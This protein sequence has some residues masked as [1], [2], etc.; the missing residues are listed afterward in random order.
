MTGTSRSIGQGKV[1]GLPTTVTG[2]ARFVADIQTV[3]AMMSADMSTTILLVEDASATA[4]SPIIGD[5]RAVV[6]TSGGPTSH[7]ALVSKEFGV[8]CVVGAV[9]VEDAASLDGTTI[10]IGADG[11]ISIVAE[12]G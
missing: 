12:A 5:A 8:P 6:C 11:E 2:I 4:V 9:L 10:M 3:I 1:V 7:L